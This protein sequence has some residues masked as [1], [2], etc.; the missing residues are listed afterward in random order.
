M[1]NRLDRFIQIL[2]TTA[3]LGLFSATSASA[4]A[5]GV[6][7]MMSSEEMAETGLDRLSAGELRRLNQWLLEHGL[8]LETDDG[9]RSQEGLVMNQ[10][11]S[12]T[13]GEAP[14]T[15]APVYGER[16]EVP[17]VLSSISGEFRGWDGKTVFRL[18]NGQIYQQ[19]RP[20]RWKT[21]LSDP[22]VRVRKVFGGFELEVEDHS[23]GVR[24]LR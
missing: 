23:I 11:V 8:P 15:P 10:A 13:A 20:G 21:R 5:Q 1:I 22:A 14:A 12:E 6:E 3:A 24:R 9:R 2:L 18:D 16:P 19:R 4:Q 17:D 7:A